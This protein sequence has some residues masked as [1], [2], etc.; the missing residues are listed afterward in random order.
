M[1]VDKFVRLRN[2]LFRMLNTNDFLREY[3]QGRNIKKSVDVITKHLDIIARGQRV[4][5]SNEEMQV[6]MRGVSAVMEKAIYSRHTKFTYDF[7]ITFAEYARIW[8]KEIGYNYNID[9]M[10]DAIRAIIQSHM[11]LIETIDVMRN[12]LSRA[13]RYLRIEPP[14]YGVSRHFLEQIFNK[15]DNGEK[16]SEYPNT[17]AN[18]RKGK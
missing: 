16:V 10:T 1:D 3:G 9:V 4:R 6:V 5:V 15:L 17:K 11:T 13:E 7:S 18:V 12:L 2:A 8:N 14:A